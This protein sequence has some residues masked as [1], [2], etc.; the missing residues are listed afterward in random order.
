MFLFLN[1]E[2]DDIIFVLFD[3]GLNVLKG[4]CMCLVKGYLFND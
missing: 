4:I 1:N 3:C 2:F